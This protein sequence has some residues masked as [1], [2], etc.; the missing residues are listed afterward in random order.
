MK[1]AKK[2][3]SAQE[4]LRKVNKEDAH[5]IVNLKNRQAI[6]FVPTGSWIIDSLIGDGTMTGKP[7]GLPRGHIVEIFGDESSGK[8]TFVL[9]AIKCAQELGSVGIL[10]D[11]E[12]TFHPDYAQK[13]GV[14]LSPDKFIL[15]QPNY[16]QQGA[17]QIF[18]M[19]MMKPYIIAV[20]SVSAMIPKEFLQGDID[21]SARI[22][23]QAQ[24]M[25]V[26]LNYITKFLKASNTNLLFTNQLRTVIKKSKYETGPDEESSGGRALKFYSSVRISLKRSIVE[27]ID[28]TSKL[29]G[30]KDKEPT[31]VTIKASVVK[32]K[33]D[34]PYKSAPVYIRFGI[35]FDNIKSIMELAINSKVIVKGGSFYSFTLNK[36]L[37]FK[38]QGKE[39]L[40]K[41]LNTDMDAFKK[42]Q[43]CLTINQD[44]E[45]QEIYQNTENEGDDFDSLMENVADSFVKK[46]KEKK[47]RK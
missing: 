11:F 15:V 1:K 41:K 9:S 26:F 25:S 21:E 7:G 47:K 30:K 28:V 5:T 22:G 40:W 17:R 32:N 16:F 37:I 13:I 31:N 12:Q 46:E 18:D 33:I 29:T 35:G 27:K 24:L 45:I 4:Y 23:L 2:P 8:T 20:D 3:L 6:D 42:V 34:K 14:D 43:D 39:Q 36:E 19:L 38:V 10:V 44:N